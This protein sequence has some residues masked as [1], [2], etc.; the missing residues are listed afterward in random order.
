MDAVVQHVIGGQ[1][2]GGTGTRF[3]DVFNPATGEVARRVALGTS[4]E[5]DAAVAAAPRPCR[6][7]PAPPRCAARGS[8]SASASCSRRTPRTGRDHHRRARQ[9]AVGCRRGGDARARGGRIR[10]R[11]PAPAQG[12]VHRERRPRRRQLLA[13]PAARRGGRHHAVQLPGHGA[14]VDVPDGAGLRQH[15][16]PQAVRARPLGLAAAGRAAARG[17]AA[18]R[19][20]QRG[21]RRQG[22]GGRA[23]G[24]SRHRRGQLRRLDPDRRIHLPHRRRA[25]Q[26]RAGAGRRQE[27][28]GRHARRRPGA[29]GRRADGCGLSARPA[30]AAWR[31]RWR[32]RSAAWATRWS[33]GWRRGCAR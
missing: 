1:R 9:G 21:E 27:P 23:P 11:H 29:G 14:A 17:R 15:L 6:A 20:V 25:R 4:A 31:S 3:A 28:H 12:R 7:G 30:S 32:S 5:V 8:C 26:A 33:S 22:G 16:H 18:G 10:L 19:R 24:P 2:T 13:A